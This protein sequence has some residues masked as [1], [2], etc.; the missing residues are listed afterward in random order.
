MAQPHASPKRVP[1]GSVPPSRAPG[2]LARIAEATAMV[3]AGIPPGVTVVAAAK[4]RGID[5]V[6]AVLDAGVSAVGHNYVQE[7][8]PMV[9]DLGHAARW[10]MIGHLQ[11]NKAGIAAELFDVVE[12][13]DNVRLAAALNRRCAAAERVMP[14]L[15][16]VNSAREP[17][18]SGVLPEDLEQLAAA[19]A[20]L[21]HLRL[22]GLMTMGPVADDPEDMRPY[23]AATREALEELRRLDLPHAELRELSMGMSD[24]Y[25]VAIEEGATM[26]RLGTVLFGPRPAR[27]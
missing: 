17:G 13:V 20:E 7:A 27:G 25:L 8:A 4:T 14:V 18:K 12:T 26:V 3:L 10:H 2:D 11:R 19:V 9:A 1:P 22:S 15:L 24:S 21:G 5:E 6:K 16:E 23:F